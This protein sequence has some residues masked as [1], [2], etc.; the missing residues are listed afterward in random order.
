MSFTN[1]FIQKYEQAMLGRFLNPDSAPEFHSS[2]S[3]ARANNWHEGDI[4]MT[5]LG[6][7]LAARA[8]YGAVI[9]YFMITAIGL[10]KVLGIA[11]HESLDKTYGSEVALPLK[12]PLF[13]WQLKLAGSGLFPKK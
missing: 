6:V 12:S 11:V 8:D 7:G 10:E 9:R 13:A 2:A 5:G 4:I 3:I 1:D